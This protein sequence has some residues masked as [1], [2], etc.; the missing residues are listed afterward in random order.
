MTSEQRAGSRG[1]SEKSAAGASPAGV[2]VEGALGGL[3]P[4]AHCDAVRPR[5]RARGFPA[6]GCAGLQLCGRRPGALSAH[7]RGIRETTGNDHDLMDNAVKLAE[8]FLYE[9]IE[10]Q[11]G[12]RSKTLDDGGQCKLTY[13][14]SAHGCKAE[15]V[16][17]SPRQFE[18]RIPHSG[19]PDTGAPVRYRCGC[20]QPTFCGKL[21][22]S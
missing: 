7:G 11:R 10:Q 4:G 21:P 3:V 2:L 1:L 6:R 20:G 14:Q 5:G 17:R 13:S 18:R 16:T 22:V 9:R 12:N 8:F 19:K 15:L